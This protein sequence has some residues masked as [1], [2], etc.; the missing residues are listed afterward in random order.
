METL[1][2][3]VQGQE[4]LEKTIEEIAITV[5]VNN[6]STRLEEL[7]KTDKMREEVI[8]YLIEIGATKAFV[9]IPEETLKEWKLFLE[10]S[11]KGK[12]CKI[13]GSVTFGKVKLYIRDWEYKVS[14][15]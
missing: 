3:L 10:G 6:C 12:P 8:D 14:I 2:T 13:S 4:E 7:R 11:C 1:R 9:S 5:A 15:M